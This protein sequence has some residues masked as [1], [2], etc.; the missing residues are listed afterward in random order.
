M[1]PINLYRRRNRQGVS[2]CDVLLLVQAVAQRQLVAAVCE[3]GRSQGVVP[4]MAVSDAKAVVR[5]TAFVQP[6]DS[7]RDSKALKAIAMW[8][9]RFSPVVAMD[10]PDGLL[11]DITGCPHLFGGEEAMLARAVSDFG[12]LGIEAV[13]AIAPT[14]GSA[15]AVARFGTPRTVV[16]HHGIREAVDPLPLESLAIDPAA[17]GG[18]HE[19]G[20]K[21]VRDL[22]VLPRGSI[23]T[24]FGDGVLR[25]LDE[26]MGPVPEIIE[27]IRPV[28]PP[29]AEQLFQGPCCCVETIGLA[30]RQV[31]DGLCAELA[32]RG[33]GVT[34]AL[35]TLHR[36]D[37][38]PLL[39]PLRLSAANRD[40]R[41]LWSLLRPRLERAH[42]GFGIEGISITA[43]RLG[44]VREEQQ[45][46]WRDGNATQPTNVAFDQLL[47]TLVNRLGKDNVLVTHDKESHLPERSQQLVSVL[48][49]KPQSIAAAVE[50]DRPTLLYEQPHPVDVIALTPD[51]PVSRL[52][53]NERVCL[54]RTCLGPERI[55]SEW[56]HRER[57]TRDYYKI[58]FE[59]GQWVWV[60]CGLEARAWFIH[61]VWA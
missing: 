59:S 60:F 4:G 6:H 20:I 18:M 61:G 54:V 35:V 24:R 15:R 22:L 55:S 1:L 58:Q 33:Q 31:L 37:L 23:A 5:G 40:S 29:H 32:Q 13:A 49:P 9:H 7:I 25:R 16:P 28:D 19:V 48:D 50:A 43:K 21:T 26:V 10:S 44:M 2:R 42:L 39:L 45:T 14:F 8:A 46:W 47:D 57:F 3:S 38:S 27:P 34:D 41:H 56:W 53:W 52:V 17:I 12:S 30:C 36:S 11:L 51:G